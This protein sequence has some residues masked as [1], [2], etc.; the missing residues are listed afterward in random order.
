[1]DA[2]CSGE[3]RREQCEEEEGPLEKPHEMT[4]AWSPEQEYVKT[5]SGVGSPYQEDGET[6]WDR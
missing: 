1:M 2:E 4:M 3:A 6:Q 5:Q